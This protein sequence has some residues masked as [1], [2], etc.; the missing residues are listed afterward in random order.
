MDVLK[1][2]RGLQQWLL[3]RSIQDVQ[4]SEAVDSAILEV[5]QN[6]RSVCSHR[7]FCLTFDLECG[8]PT[9]DSWGGV[10]ALRGMAS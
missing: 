1:S 2:S 5:R 10:E 4:G 9:F 3:W 7:T 6:I 8:M